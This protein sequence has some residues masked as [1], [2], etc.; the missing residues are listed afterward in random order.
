MTILDQIIENKRQEVAQRKLNTSVTALE[1]SALFERNTLPMSEYILDI[2]KTGIIAEFKRKSP[3]R[4][5]I[6]AGVTVEEITTGYFRSGASALSILTDFT[7]FGG[8]DNDLVRA[9]E[10]NAIPILRKDFMIDEYQI[11]ESKAMGADAVLLI[12]SVLERETILS[13]ARLARSIGLQVMLEIHE[14]EEMKL[15]N[16]FIDMIG[17]N[18]RDLKTFTVDLECSF[19]LIGM[20][21]EG[22]VRISESGISSPLMVQKLKNA[23]FQGFLMGESFMRAPDPVLVFSKFVEHLI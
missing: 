9:R 18:N 2:E 20:I 23:G 7:F 19:R 13:L 6:N 3:S 5:M 1:H 22:F 11:F 8:T 12:A 15:I 4:G 16:E 21:P 10:L 17:V 14:P